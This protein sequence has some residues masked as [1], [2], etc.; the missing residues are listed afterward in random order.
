MLLNMMIPAQQLKLEG[1][2]FRLF[3]RVEP[4]PLRIGCPE[5]MMQ[6]KPIQIGSPGPAH[7]A[8]PSE[9]RMGFLA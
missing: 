4:I 3:D 7:L 8:L 1:L 6:L 5:A 9:Q 2:G